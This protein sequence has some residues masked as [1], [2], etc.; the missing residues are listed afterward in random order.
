MK[1]TNFEQKEKVFVPI[2]NYQAP[3]TL[4]ACVKLTSLAE[5]NRE[6]VVWRDSKRSALLPLPIPITADSGH[7]MTLSFSAP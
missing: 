6:Y 3:H 7:H 2:E 4:A 5:E 1:K